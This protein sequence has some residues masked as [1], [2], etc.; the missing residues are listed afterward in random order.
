DG[1]GLAFSIKIPQNA[2][3]SARVML[4]MRSASGTPNVKINGY[5]VDVISSTEMYYDITNI[6][7][8]S[9]QITSAGGSA[10]ITVNNTGGGL[11]ALD[12]I[13][14]VNCSEGTLSADSISDVS[15]IMSAPSVH[16]G[17]DSLT[18]SS[19]TYSY[20]Y[21]NSSADA[22]GELNPEPEQPSAIDEVLN[23]IVT[24]L[25]NAFEFVKTAFVNFIGFFNLLKF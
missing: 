15:A 13:K 6:L 18:S 17:L 21:D 12:N 8:E 23:R 9:G 22:E 7:I 1:N 10:T 14:L 16:I 11:L 2:L 20:K 3:A 24:F 19:N 5:D 25:Q 4:S